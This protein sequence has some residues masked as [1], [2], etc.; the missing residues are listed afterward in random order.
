MITPTSKTSPPPLAH[1]KLMVAK[2]QAIQWGIFLATMV[3]IPV[4]VWLWRWAI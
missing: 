3:L 4:T 1:E 2:A